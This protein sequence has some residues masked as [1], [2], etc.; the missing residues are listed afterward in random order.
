R[1]APG[2]RATLHRRLG[3]RMEVV[4]ATQLHDVAAEL[5]YHFEAGAA[6][7]RAVTYLRVVAET[8]EQRYAYRE[9]ATALQRALAL[10]HHLPETPER[11]QQSLTLH[12]ALGAAQLMTKG[13]AAPEVEH[14]YTQARALCQQ[15]S[16]TPE[17]V[18]VLLGLWR[19]YIAGAQLHT[20]RELGETLL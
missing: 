16:E 4:C 11:T 8:A 19:Y 2:R 7:A 3:E 20:A 10:V 6:W 17:I 14:T 12:L 9:A 15:V 5:A 18:P 13:H 1:Q